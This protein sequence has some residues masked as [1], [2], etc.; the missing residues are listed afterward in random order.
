MWA[1]GFHVSRTQALGLGF[2]EWVTLCCNVNSQRKME[3]AAR[4]ESLKTS[5][6][7]IVGNG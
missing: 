2:K 4:T 5:G 1:L 6:W 7:C 3:T